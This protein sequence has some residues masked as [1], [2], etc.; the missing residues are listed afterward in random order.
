MVNQ[1][2]EDLSPTDYQAVL[3][4]GNIAIDPPTAIKRW[5]ENFKGTKI[6]TTDLIESWEWVG[7]EITSTE[8]T[9][10][11]AVQL[12]KSLAEGQEIDRHAGPS[13][14]LI[15]F[16]IILGLILTPIVIS[17]IANILSN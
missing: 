3:I 11:K 2:W 8:K 4:P 9:A 13:G 12:I 15:A 1:S 7:I 14:W 17:L 5:L 6:I 16:Y 10:K